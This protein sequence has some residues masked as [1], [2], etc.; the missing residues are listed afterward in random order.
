[1]P[2]VIVA[3]YLATLAC[4]FTWML[5]TYERGDVLRPRLGQIFRAWITEATIGPAVFLWWQPFRSRVIPDRLTP[6]PCGRRGMVFVHGFFCNRGVWTRWLRRTDRNFVAVDLEPAFGSI[7][8]YGDA[9][10]QA[11]D[12]ITQST[13]MTPIV[14]AHSMGG[15]AVRA[16]LASD[17]QADK[18]HRVVTIATPHAGTRAARYAGS[19]NGAQMA[20]GSAWLAEL[21]AREDPKVR[22]RFVCFW[23][24]CD[25]IVF[26]VRSAMLDGADNRHLTATPHVRMVF[27]RDIFAAVMALADDDAVPSH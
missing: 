19:R 16:W 5:S 9:I 18:V 24:H 7:D 2:A 22:P 27:H 6:R 10:G 25:N 17:G 13:G 8:R 3:G 26:P 1:M 14:V 12:R 20:E 15:L 11:V 21:A 4:E 23:G